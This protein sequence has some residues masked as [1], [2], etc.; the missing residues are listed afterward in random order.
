MR[1]PDKGGPDANREEWGQR[2]TRTRADARRWSCAVTPPHLA[3]RF[4][5]RGCSE[6]LP[7]SNTTPSFARGP[8]R[9]TTTSRW[10]FD[11][12]CGSTASRKLFSHRPHEAHSSPV[13]DFSTHRSIW[14]SDSQLWSFI[15][16]SHDAC[17]CNDGG[18]AGIGCFG[19]LDKAEATSVCTNVFLGRVI[20]GWR[21]IDCD[22][23]THAHL[24]LVGVDQ[25][26]AGFA[27]LVAGEYTRKCF[28]IGHT[29]TFRDAS[30]VA[31]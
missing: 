5:T 6:S 22:R 8:K 11:T 25:S 12:Q 23:P 2:P 10:S 26:G 30:H 19:L 24:P 15:R 18:M 31:H 14:L 1:G 28:W 16:C 20:D 17:F 13:A 9:N 21:V 29:V 4:R 27:Y 7:I 3:L